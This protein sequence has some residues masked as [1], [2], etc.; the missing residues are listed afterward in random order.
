MRNSSASSA[1]NQEEPEYS[2]RIRFARPELD[3]LVRNWT[4]V[5]MHFHSR[6]SDGL[7]DIP[8]IA[9]RARRLNIGIALTDH[10]AVEGAVRISE[11]RDVFSIPGIEITSREGAH[12]LA[13]FYTVDELVRFYETELTP[14]LGREIMSSS[15]LSMESLVA[16]VRRYR[17]V[18]VFPHPYCAMFTGVCNPVFTR[19]RQNFLL[20]AVDG[21]EVVNAGNM[22]RWNLKSAALVFNTDMGLTGGSDGHNLFQLGRAV[23]CTSSPK[24]AEAFLDAVRNRQACVVG[25]EINILRKMTTTGMKI[26]NNLRNSPDLFGKNVR[27]GCAVINRR[28]RRIKERIKK[29]RAGQI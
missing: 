4:V 6:Y 18:V 10:N 17:G 24:T 28:S 19:R 12:L 3:A 26:R 11:Y 15:W 5:D 25:K 21:I 13:Y 1:V 9:E 27:Y 23:T 8:A 16:S 7:N 20:S 22:H 2:P 14:Y 29:Y